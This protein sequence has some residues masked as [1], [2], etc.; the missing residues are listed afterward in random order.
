MAQ[1]ASM[2]GQVV[3]NSSSGEQLR[4]VGHELP[5]VAKPVGKSVNQKSGN[6]LLQPYDPNN[7][8]GQLAGTGLNASSVV[9][10]V[11]GFSTGVPQST[12]QQIVTKMKSF[13]GISTP[14]KIVPIYTPGIYRRDRERV[15]ERMWMRD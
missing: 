10:P 15:Q 3:S 7:P 13:V 9:A 1:N 2:P 11:N 4:M 6:P 5:Q 12:F 14:P 8:Y